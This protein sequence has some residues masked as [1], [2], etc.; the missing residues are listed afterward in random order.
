MK[1]ASEAA[2]KFA[3]EIAGEVICADDLQRLPVQEAQTPEGAEKV[4]LLSSRA[5]REICFL[6]KMQKKTE[7]SGKNSSSE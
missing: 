2:E 6:V 3:L 1:A 5:R 7:S 4:L